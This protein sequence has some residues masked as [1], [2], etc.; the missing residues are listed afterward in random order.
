MP[1]TTFLTF[2]LTCV[3]VQLSAASALNAQPGKPA[4]ASAPTA[5][6]LTVTT[7]YPTVRVSVV[8]GVVKATLPTTGTA[9]EQRFRVR[10]IRPDG[11][12]IAGAAVDFEAK[13]DHEAIGL[14]ESA[15]G[16]VPPTF[17]VVTD[18]NGW[19]R[20]DWT[21]DTRY[22]AMEVRI[23]GADSWTNSFLS[24][25]AGTWTLTNLELIKA[26]IR[27]CPRRVSLR[28]SGGEHETIFVFYKQRKVEMF[29]N[30]P[31]PQ[32]LKFYRYAWLVPNCPE[33]ASQMEPNRVGFYTLKVPKSQREVLCFFEVKSFSTVIPIPPGDGDIVLPPFTLPEPARSVAVQ[34]TSPVPT[35][36]ADEMRALGAGVFLLALDGSSFWI[37]NWK[38]PA[39]QPNRLSMFA[40]EA[41]EPIA[42]SAGVYY[43]IVNGWQ[44]RS[45]ILAPLIAAARAGRDLT[46]LGIP[47][48]T[49]VAGQPWTEQLDVQPHI[50]AVDAAVATLRAEG[51]GRYWDEPEPPAG[52]P[53]V[54]PR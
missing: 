52:P 34:V 6:D 10:F 37:L 45:H 23:A 51:F 53:V 15:V 13:S 5:S 1:A 19:A 27:L 4:P 32:P 3:C 33:A 48:R 11:T 50:V 35:V 47:K 22:N 14:Q 24:G 7:N 25:I 39:G 12:P 40:P 9:V 21:I 36:P 16:S 2:I 20:L 29:A 30:V 18:A 31:K 38:S 44:R 49:L 28:P 42:V 41:Q 17:R 46:Q 43:M 54:P 26:G 8:D